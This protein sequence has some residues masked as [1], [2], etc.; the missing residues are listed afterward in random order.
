[1][2]RRARSG[3]SP[4]PQPGGCRS[5]ASLRV[6]SPWRMRERFALTWHGLIYRLVLGA[7]VLAIVVP[8]TASG[9]EPVWPFVLAAVAV[10]I[11]G[12][13]VGHR[14]PVRAWLRR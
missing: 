7:I 2:S 14:P 1:M 10:V 4:E 6:G 5:Q 13:L 9:A 11:L 3:K 12:I 8:T